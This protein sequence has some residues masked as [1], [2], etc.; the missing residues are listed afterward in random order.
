[1]KFSFGIVVFGGFCIVNAAIDLDCQ[2]DGWKVEIRDIAV[3][4]G[5]EPDIFVAVLTFK[6][7]F[8][9]FLSPGRMTA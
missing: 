3:D 8:Q 9:M 7:A 2:L 5:L 1:V 4:D 6:M